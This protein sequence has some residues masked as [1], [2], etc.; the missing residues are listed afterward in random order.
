MN[1][2]INYWAEIALALITLMSTLTAL[3]EST[4]DDKIVAVL[5]RVLNAI[6]F[7]RSKSRQKKGK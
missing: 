3:T 2:L 6:V 4:R 1:F 5:S 7:G